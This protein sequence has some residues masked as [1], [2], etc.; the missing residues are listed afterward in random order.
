VGLIS[1]NNNNGNDKDDADNGNGKEDS[2]AEDPM[3]VSIG[4]VRA[5]A[6]SD[7]TSL[8]FAS[9]ARSAAKY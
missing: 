2:H 8:S 9:R 1:E 4:Q 3:T 5:K 6:R 7:F